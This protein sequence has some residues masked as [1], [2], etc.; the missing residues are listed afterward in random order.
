MRTRRLGKRHKKYAVGL[1]FDGTCTSSEDPL[2][3]LI[4]ENLLTGEA[5]KA[6]KDQY[7]RYMPKALRGELSPAQQM[8]WFKGTIGAYVGQGLTLPQIYAVIDRVKLRPG[9]ME[10]C[11]HLRSRGIPTAIISFGGRQFIRRV[12]AN[13][14]PLTMPV[15]AICAA[16]LHVDPVTRRIQGLWDESIVIPANK[17]EWSRRFAD[18]HD[19]PYENILAVGDTWGDSKLGHLKENRLGIVEDAAGAQA[20]A[21]AF[22]EVV[23][24]KDFYPVIDWILRKLNGT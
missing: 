18:E 24:T 8:T 16:D 21:G 13:H 2:M 4:Y 23:V 17:G 3:K 15:D 14:S 10:L 22:G 5:R 12:A 7:D 19:V 11:G 1:D 20:I 6:V 9:V